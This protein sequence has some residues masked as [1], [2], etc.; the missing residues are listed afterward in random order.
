MHDFGVKTRFGVVWWRQRAVKVFGETLEV[1]WKNLIFF[2]KKCPLAGFWGAGFYTWKCISARKLPKSILWDP[3]HAWF[4]NK[5]RFWGRLMA[6]ESCQT[7]FWDPRRCLKKSDVFFEEIPTR[8]ILGC[9]FLHVKS[10]FSTPKFQNQLF[11]TQK[12]MILE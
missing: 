9:L 7:I 12:C 1:A 2:A 11:G 3:K 6:S 5:N 10:Y 8:G 4:C